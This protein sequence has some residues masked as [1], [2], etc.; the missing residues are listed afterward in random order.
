MSHVD[1]MRE[2]VRSVGTAAMLLA[3]TRTI[4]DEEAAKKMVSGLGYRLVVTEVG[5]NSGLSEFQSKTTRAV[6]GAAHNSGL[7]S[8]SPTNYHALLHAVEEAKR[9]FLANLSSASSL[10]V[11]I[12]IVRDDKWIAVAFFGESAIHP[13]TNHERTGLGIMHMGVDD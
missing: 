7:L 6:I 9:G 11:K 2:S 13:V 3:L 10:A 4:S 1:F 8:K 5:G 12:A